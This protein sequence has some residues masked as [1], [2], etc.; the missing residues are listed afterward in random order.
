MKLLEK[1]LQIRVK[2]IAW[3]FNDVIY[4]VVPESAQQ[5]EHI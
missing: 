1:K 4:E 3:A 2:I 5:L